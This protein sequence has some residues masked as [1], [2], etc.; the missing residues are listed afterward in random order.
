MTDAPW[1]I[2][3][4]T[5]RVDAALAGGA[6]QG[7]PSGRVR[8]RPTTRTIRWYATIGLLDRPAAMR[9][10]T[11][12]YGVRHLLQ[13]VAVKRRQAAGRTI[14]EIQAELAGAPDRVLAEIA[15]VPAELLDP[16]RPTDTPAGP[17]RAPRSGDRAAAQDARRPAD[18]AAPTRPAGAFWSAPPPTATPRPR[19]WPPPR[20]AGTARHGPTRRPPVPGRPARTARHEPS[21][22][23]V[24]TRC[25]AAGSRRRCC[26]AYPWTRARCCC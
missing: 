26:S 25:G 11:A 3:E 14:A 17:A 2:E 8:D 1:T 20:P 18:A 13:L 19:R 6:Y 16:G 7:I 4:L 22:R 9:G 15:E 5:G 24:V 10:R 12:Y 21:R 23:A